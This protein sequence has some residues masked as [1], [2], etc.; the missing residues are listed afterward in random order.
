MY[1]ST[2]KIILASSNI[3]YSLNNPMVKKSK[4]GAIK[5]RTPKNRFSEPN[6]LEDCTVYMNYFYFGSGLSNRVYYISLKVATNDKRISL[7]FV[8]TIKTKK[9]RQ[10]YNESSVATMNNA[11]R[12]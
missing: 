8:L 11:D 4:I 6:R 2:F 3:E 12:N 1:R 9:P 7:T 5:I 10:T